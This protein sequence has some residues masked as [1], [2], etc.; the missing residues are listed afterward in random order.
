MFEVVVVT[1]FW[2]V[3]AFFHG[4]RGIGV[5]LGRMLYDIFLRDHKGLVSG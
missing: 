3:K 1:V 4:F 5:V 2:C